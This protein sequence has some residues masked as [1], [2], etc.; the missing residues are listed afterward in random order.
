ME[1]KIIH[2]DCTFRDGGYYTKWDF[3][4]YLIN[5]YLSALDAISIDFCEIGFRYFDNNS[6]KGACAFT[7]DDFLS[8]LSIPD[9]I[10]IAVMINAADLIPDNNFSFTR[11]NKLVPAACK[12]SPVDLIRIACPA[13]SIHCVKPAFEYLHEAGYKTGCNI[14]QISDQTNQDI[15]QIGK[16][17]SSSCVDVLYFADSLG[18][19]KPDQI[20]NIISSFKLYWKGQIGIHAHDNQGLALSNTLQAI[21]EGVDWVDS[22]IT[23]I[24]RGPGNAKTEELILELNSRF[25]RQTNYVPLLKLINKEFLPLKA[26]HSWGTNPF[27]YLAGKYSI[28]P[29]YIQSMLSDYRYQEEDILASIN[30]LR[31]QGGK[32]FNF[33][34]LNDT[35]KFYNNKPKGSWSPSLYFKG[36]D[37]LLLGTGSKLQLHLKAVESFISRFQP[38]VLAM[39]TQTLINND[40]IDL[41]VASHP[42]RLLADLTSHLHLP[43]P[44]V[45]PLSMLPLDFSSLLH[46]KEVLDYGI[47]ISQEG[48]EFHDKYCFIPNS[49]VISYALAIATSGGAKKIYLAGFDGYAS[50]DTRNDEINQLLEVYKKY[51][52]KV[53][54][55]AITPSKYKNL[56][57]QSVY[58][59]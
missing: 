10:G 20:K 43:Q 40:L 9:S 27:Y 31:D 3:S 57:I 18:S 7:T 36:K 28:H 58:G 54:L 39:N 8:S 4:E 24:G 19:I 32:K 59:I 26:K 45:V 35:R 14:T 38:V 30:Y 56:M 46:K 33:T 50:G 44:L 11:L 5:N 29:S 1:K 25:G 2:L 51:Q 17:L 21:K 48:F 41:R 23:G 12:D 6:F 15:E 37:V 22:T 47:G 16:Y 49:L 53:E 13:D 34:S 55:I 52:P 42:T